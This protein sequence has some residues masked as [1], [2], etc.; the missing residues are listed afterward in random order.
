MTTPGISLALVLHNHQPVGNFE[1][2]LDENH[3]LAYR[4]MLEALDRHPGI[5]VGL[6]YS[7][8]LLEWLRAERPDTVELICRL[9]ERGQ[10]ELLGGGYY[11]PVLNALPDADRVGQLER[12]AVELEALTGQRPRGAW[13]AER[14][15]EPDLPS[16]LHE[17][18]YEYTVLDDAHLRAAGIPD[19][20]HWGIYSTDDRGRRVLVFPTEQGLR[21]RIPFH[22]VEDTIEHLRAHAT[23][24]RDRIGMMGD[25]GEKFGG[26]PT[27]WELCWGREAWVERFFAAVEANAAWLT[28][29]RP[30]DAIDGQRPLGRVYVPTSSYAEMGE[31]SLPPAERRD[32]T[33][34]LEAARNDGRGEARWMRGGFWRQFGAHYREIAD[35][36]ER[37]LRASQKV[38]ALPPGDAR[39]AVARDHLYRGQSNDCYWHGLF[40]GIYLSHLRLA[41]SAELIAAEDVADHVSGGID[42]STLEIGDVD[43]DGRDE[44]LVSAPGQVLTI[45][46]DDGGGIAAW[47]IRPVRHALTSVMR[48]RREAYHDAIDG[49]AESGAGGEGLSI[50]DSIRTTE[51][52]LAERLWRDGHER[53][54]G[55][56]RVLP[57]SIGLDELERGHDADSLVSADHELVLAGVDGIRL[58]GRATLAEA[59]GAPRPIAIAKTYAIGGD[60]RSPTLD[61]DVT[62]TNPG[63]TRLDGRLALE[64]SL[65]MLGGGGNP[66]ASIVAGGQ[67]HRFD[68]RGVLDD[69]REITLGNDRIGIELH[70]RATPGASLWWYSIDTVSLSEQGFERSHQG[71]CL[72]WSWDLALEPGQSIQVG[73]SSRVTTTVDRAVSE[74]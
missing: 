5:R 17:A 28:S 41:T 58:D 64:W 42:D 25:D 14:V 56:V 33:R 6:H 24:D 71:M 31:W 49:S 30:G 54:S 65:N 18:G 7:G 61:L 62:A 1:H 21:H 43:L 63:A 32:F 2:V 46:P 29:L 36:H 12:M 35:L 59:D 23:V 52:G 47:D 8:A 4:P 38:A 53:R 22:P 26:W 66:Q 57:P 11:E 37:M 50:D 39:T 3:R 10:V 27:T 19:E 48:R 34:A 60:R 51:E 69:A 74:T 9:V 70:Q 73:V 40:G 15:W 55:L 72:V 20:R 13:L 45:K 67:R 44:I 68:S 16:A